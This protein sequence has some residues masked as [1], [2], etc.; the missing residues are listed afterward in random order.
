LLDSSMPESFP[1]AGGC[2][3]GLLGTAVV[4]EFRGTRFHSGASDWGMPDSN[5]DAH[6]L[7]GAGGCWNDVRGEPLERREVTHPPRPLGNSRPLG[8]SRPGGG[9]KP[10]GKLKVPSDVDGGS[11][12]LKSAAGKVTSP[13][14]HQCC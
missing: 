8:S 9:L 5:C 13:T 1:S 6:G 3:S 14:G 4:E 7:P 12:Q 10:A 2:A 11:V